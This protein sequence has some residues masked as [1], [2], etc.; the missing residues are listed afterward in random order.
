MGKTKYNCVKGPISLLNEPLLYE[1][2]LGLLNILCWF[3]MSF[4]FV[5]NLIVP[6]RIGQ[7]WV[8]KGHFWLSLV[9]CFSDVS[10][11]QI[12]LNA[13]VPF[14]RASEGLSNDLLLKTDPNGFSGEMLR[15]LCK[16]SE[17]RQF[18]PLFCGNGM[19]THFLSWNLCVKWKIWSFTTILYGFKSGSEL[20]LWR[21]D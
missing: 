21:N 13:I 12:K 11:P 20:I 8:E 1:T 3:Q 7:I 5:E 19:V 16:T 17:N 4:D 15:I 2:C 14:W 18:W 10:Y 9:L 6:T